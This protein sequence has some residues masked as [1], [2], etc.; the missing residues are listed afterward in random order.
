MPGSVS[1]CMIV[2]TEEAHLAACLR[3]GAGLVKE[4]IGVDTGSTDRTREI[5]VSQGA[6]VFD[7][8]WCDDFSAARNEA[9]RRATGEWIF[10]MDADDRL[11]ETN[12]ERLTELFDGL[13]DERWLVS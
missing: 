10:W 6:K 11:D 9:L 8:P 4:M 12:R 3:S 2:K 5:A 13:T 7:F 1:L